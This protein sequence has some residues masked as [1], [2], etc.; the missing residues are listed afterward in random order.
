MVADMTGMGGWF[1]VQVC[2]KRANESSHC[3]PR[4]A[5]NAAVPGESI[6]LL[7]PPVDAMR[8]LAHA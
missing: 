1:L 4:R 8:G 7:R 2:G 3:L 5:C 6:R